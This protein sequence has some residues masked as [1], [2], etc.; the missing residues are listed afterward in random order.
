MPCLFF[1][2]WQARVGCKSGAVGWKPP[3]LVSFDFAQSARITDFSRAFRMAVECDHIGLETF[4]TFFRATAILIDRV[5]GSI[6]S[7]KL[8]QNMRR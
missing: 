1:G 4:K 7:L 5:H 3:V 2:K 6:S 8:V